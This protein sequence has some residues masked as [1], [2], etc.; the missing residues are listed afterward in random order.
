[1]TRLKPRFTNVLVDPGEPSGSQRPP[2]TQ[3]RR[4]LVTLLA[5]QLFL[6]FVAFPL[7][8][9]HFENERVKSALESSQGEDLPG[10][11]SYIDGL[12][13]SLVTP[14][15]LKSREP[16][17]QS[18]KG[19]LVVRISDAAK[20]L[21]IGV[22]VRLFHDIIIS[23]KTRDIPRLGHMRNRRSKDDEPGQP[24]SPQQLFIIE[25]RFAPRHNTYAPRIVA[26]IVYLLGVGDPKHKDPGDSG[27]D[28]PDS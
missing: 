14:I 9:I 12:Y 28:T 15:A 7:L 13:W 23:H 2:P 6:L 5:I 22:T 25:K 11:Y 26:I 4:I 18:S 17:P 27:E 10:Q 20:L 16:W 8:M 21:T 3:K 1:M 19:W 24:M